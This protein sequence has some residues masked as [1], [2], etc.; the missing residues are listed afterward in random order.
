MLTLFLPLYSERVGAA[1]R[2]VA[3]GEDGGYVL[4]EDDGGGTWGERRERGGAE[5]KSEY[6]DQRHA[7]VLLKLP[8]LDGGGRHHRLLIS[9]LPA[10]VA[11]P[12]LPPHITS[13]TTHVA[14]ACCA[15]PRVYCGGRF[16]R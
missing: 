11:R 15:V 6:A 2:D 9:S 12:S 3:A 5:S 10:A 1:V 8:G 7:R 13:L 16:L 4:H 14:E